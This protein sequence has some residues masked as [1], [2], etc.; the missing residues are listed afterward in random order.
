[1]SAGRVEFFLSCSDLTAHH[2][3]VGVFLK[4]IETNKWNEVGRTEV[5]YN[6]NPKFA[7]Q[8]MVDFIFEEE[9]QL[10][11]DVYRSINNSQA[12][13]SKHVIGSAAFKL[14]EVVHAKHQMLTRTLTKGRKVVKNRASKR[15]SRLNIRLEPLNTDCV[16]NTAY[17]FEASDLPKQGAFSKA[18]PILEIHR[19]GSDGKFF[20]VFETEVAKK[21]LS[22]NWAEFTLTSTQL[23]NGDQNRTLQLKIYH[24]EKEQRKY[25]GKCQSNYN[26]LL[27]DPNKAY[28]IKDPKGKQVGT[29]KLTNVRVLSRQQNTMDAPQQ[30]PAQSTEYLN[31]SNAV[32][33]Q[34]AEM[35]E[36]MQ[37][38]TIRRLQEQKSQRSRGKFLSYLQG[39]CEISLMVA[40]DFTGSNGYVT[41]PSSLHYIYK[42]N[43]PSPYQAALRSICGIVAPYDSDQKFPVWGF[44]AK[45]PSMPQ[46]AHD[47]DVNPSGDEVDGVAGIEE[48]YV[49]AIQSSA[50]QLSGPCCYSPILTKAINETII[51]HN[52]VMQDQNEAIQYYILLI[53]TNG[54]CCEEDKQPTKNL[55]I[56]AS[57]NNLPLSIIFVGI[58]D[59]K[60]DFL[61]ELDG[62]FDPIK[63]DKG[64]VAKRD[65]VQFVEM[66]QFLNK[67]KHELSR[68]TLREIPIQ[69]V[70]YV[71][72]NH[73]T[74]RN[75]KM[76]ALKRSASKFHI[77]DEEDEDGRTHSKG[78]TM[79][80]IADDDLAD[81]EE[82]EDE[83]EGGSVDDAKQPET[84][85]MAHVP[86]PI[87][88]EKSYTA[89]G[90]VFYINHKNKSTQWEHPLKGQM[91]HQKQSGQQQSE[92]QKKQQA[93]YNLQLTNNSFDYNTTKRTS[94]AIQHK[95]IQRSAS[96]RPSPQPQQPQRQPVQRA[97]TMR[98]QPSPVTTYQQSPHQQ[99]QQVVYA[100]PQSPQQ[101]YVQPQYAQ[102][103]PQYAQ[104]QSPQQRVV[105][106]QPQQPQQRVAYDQYGRQ[107]VLPG[108]QQPQP[109]VVYAQQPQ[110]VQ[111]AQQPQVV[112]GQPQQPQVRYVQQ[113]PQQG[114]VYYAQQQPQQGQPVYY[115]QQPQQQYRKNW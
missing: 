50:F 19:L 58:G 32:S 59:G 97:Q 62:D 38:D 101:Q 57:N 34:Q 21:T 22:P 95:P 70:S 31:A 99:P 7:K 13:I 114:Q 115:Q 103:Q 76:F 46:V 47:F 89:T 5:S 37:K 11:F 35:E 94:T 65:I 85:A 108:G 29:L 48:A 100:Q 98:Q 77:E 8:F 78:D 96:F 26:K 30:Q 4:D 44:G 112:Y 92:L 106:A 56:Y 12:F 53:L 39:S 67:D 80:Q 86:V 69:F 40:V 72:N 88:W 25:I 28:P 2:A 49:T 43:Q 41:D 82:E 14:S 93:A 9:Q 55:L 60:F 20:K 84:D 107:I 1:M 91:N 79:F 24:V 87:G 52:K 51:A 68:Y 105:Y 42:P 102:P 81:S 45:F 113:Q 63:D 15:Y 104:P 90:R 75:K 10:R 54:Q 23:C 110:Q 66:N 64:Q 109:Q 3:F 27:N 71:D 18:N 111:Y 16:D 83:P 73:I 33:A 61:N 36:K 17:N 74:P 6:S